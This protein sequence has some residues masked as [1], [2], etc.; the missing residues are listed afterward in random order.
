MV[1][2]L[3][4]KKVTK[5]EELQVGEKAVRLAILA[6]RMQVPDG[7]VIT[8]EVFTSFLKETGLLTRINNLI[9]PLAPEDT[10]S[11]QDVANKIQKL[12]VTTKIPAE[13]QEEICNH[14]V[15]L[16]FNDERKQ[17]IRNLIDEASTPLVAVR[18]SACGYEDYAKLHVSFV[19]IRGVDRFV[20]AVLAS[21]ASFYMAKAIAY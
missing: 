18:S 8:N 13:L 4:L 20:Q 12:I 10:D 15:C 7:F 21:W 17:G 1:H 2:I 14:Y 9:A 3:S 11:L 16:N 5:Q 19:N 6:D